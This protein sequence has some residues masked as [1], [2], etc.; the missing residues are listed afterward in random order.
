MSCS[1]SVNSF[2]SGAQIVVRQLSKPCGRLP[3]GG[4]PTGRC[5]STWLPQTR[6]QRYSAGSRER[7]LASYSDRRLPSLRAGARTFK[8]R[9][10]LITSYIDLPPNYK[11]EDGLPFR[12]TELEADEIVKIFGP[13]MKKSDGNRLLKVLHGRRVA[14]TVHDPTLEVHTAMYSKEQKR[15]A[16]EYLR[17]M[18]PIDEVLNAGLRAEEELAKLEGGLPDEH[19]IKG[20]TV[21]KPSE[22]SGD[23][24]GRGVFDVIREQNEAKARAEEEAKRLLKEE[25]RKKEEEEMAKMSPKE[26]EAYV[27]RKKGLTG[28][29]PSAKMQAYMEAAQSKLEAPP[30]MS[31]WERIGPSAVVVFLVSGLLVAYAA[32]YRPLKRSDR[33][34]PDIPPAAATVGTIIIA[35]IAIYGL[36]K[37]PKLWPMMNKYFLVV[38]ATPRVLGIYGATFSHQYFSH[39]VVNMAALWF[40]GT[41]YYD[42]VGRGDFLATYFTAGTMGF[43]GTLTW[44]VLRNQL[45]LTSL[46]ASGGFYGLAGAYFW[47]HRSEGF[48]LFGLP[49]DPYDGVPGLAFIGT[50]IGLN[51]AAAFSRNAGWDVASHMVGMAVGI[52]AGHIMEKKKEAKRL[53]QEKPGE[54]TKIGAVIPAETV[55]EK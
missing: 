9:N 53:A 35:N 33:L 30:E 12:S 10:V 36:W 2:R 25:K 47:M 45:H 26:L 43:L 50:I 32:Y 1:L 41:A 7:N 27:E 46:G 39:L 55:K 11:D 24:Y 6:N 15:A 31:K 20:V 17:R 21:R 38:P 52:A 37:V 4:A 19:D 44:T 3:L 40:V 54:R 48:K 49:P 8:V 28:R 13:Y 22:K 42:E 51:I 16:L 23:V 18:A 34:L 5:F 29:K 14:G